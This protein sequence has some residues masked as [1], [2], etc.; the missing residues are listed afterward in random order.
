YKWEILNA[1]GGVVGT[2]DTGRKA[3]SAIPDFV[4][5]RTVFA[6]AQNWKVRLTL[7][8]AN[9]QAV[10]NPADATVFAE[11]SPLNGPTPS[12]ALTR[13]GCDNAGSPCSLSVGT[14]VAQ[15]DPASWCYSWSVSG[16]ATIT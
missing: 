9:P 6:G 11:T 5:P 13:S 7:T 14:T 15:N 3:L 4:R 1:T 8:L 10:T 12:A 16:A 2:A